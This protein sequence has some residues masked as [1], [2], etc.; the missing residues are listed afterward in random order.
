VRGQQSDKPQLVLENDHGGAHILEAEQLDELLGERSVAGGACSDQ[1][2][3]NPP[4]IF[5]NSCFSESIA[6]LL[7]ES[8]SPVVL[9]TRGDLP[10]KVA[11]QFTHDFYFEL[12]SKQSV[13]VSFEN[14]RKALRLHADPTFKDS[15]GSFVLFGQ[16][17][18][19]QTS[20]SSSSVSTPR[21]TVSAADRIAWER[22]RS[23]SGFPTVPL[24]VSTESL[25]GADQQQGRRHAQQ[26]E[27]FQE[28]DKMLPAKV[29]DFVGRT[30][31]L[32][33]ILHPFLAHNGASSPT[34]RAC[35]VSGPEGIGKSALAAE[36][37][38]F[39]AAPGRPFGSRVLHTHLKLRKGD[40]VANRDRERR[41]PEDTCSVG[42]SRPGMSQSDSLQLFLDSL[43]KSLPHC[44]TLPG[45][46]RECQDKRLCLLRQ[47]Q[48]IDK[49]AKRTLMLVDDSVGIFKC[50][51]VR[52]VLSELLEST[53][54]ISLVL[55]SREHIYE[56][57]GGHK[58][59]NIEL[60]SL[61]RTDSALLFL[62]RIHRPLVGMDFEGLQSHPDQRVQQEQALQALVRHR[63]MDELQD[64]PKS[65]RICSEKVTPKLRSL[66]DLCKSS[67]AA[68]PASFAT[69]FSHLPAFGPLFI[70]G[71][72]TDNSLS[73]PRHMSIDSEIGQEENNGLQREMSIDEHL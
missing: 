61:R 63:L 18:A 51:P 35:V 13:Q 7:I 25:S 36:L 50:Q 2:N 16:H 3:S 53:Q 1:P 5:I 15:E 59:V 48:E 8:G 26:P 6:E 46:E 21:S 30:D 22:N 58:C 37:A 12:G 66:L 14:A 41:R 29:E 62:R 67:P 34:R 44:P 31:V 27:F 65:L 64:N 32:L 56:S 47:L 54:G 17:I 52:Q 45:D 73:L 69:G 55:F 43:A 40:G 23:S 10:D 72:Q 19:K 4:L 57:L 38:R 39:A 33:R 11:R 20:L 24:T 71:C 28:Q 60:G 9:A 70:P 42:G 68:A 49:A